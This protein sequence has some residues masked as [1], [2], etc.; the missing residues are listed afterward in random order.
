VNN[1]AGVATLSPSGVA[2]AG[3]ATGAVAGTAEITATFGG[4]SGTSILTVNAATLVSVIVSPLSAT[5]SVGDAQQFTAMANYSFGPDVDVTENAGTVWTTANNPVGVP[6]TLVA[7]MSP[8]GVVGAGLATGLVDGTSDIT[9]TYNLMTDTATLI[10]EEVVIIPGAVCTVDSGPTIP[11]V[12]ESNPTDGNLL[13]TT[14]TAGVANNGKLITANFDMVMD[15]TTIASAT[16][17]LTFTIMETVSL[18][19]VSGT[20]TMDLTNTIATFTTDAALLE[21]MAYTASITSDAM[22]AGG[23]AIA[24]PYEWNFTTVTPAAI[25]VGPVNLGTAASFGIA[26]VAGVENTGA[27]QI[28]GDVVLNTLDQCNAVTVDNAGGFGLCGGTPPT[29]NGEVITPT[30]PDLTTA[31]NVTDDLRAA[32]LSITPANMP[33]ATA[34]AAGTTLGAPIGNA[35]VE[36]DNLFF[37]GVYQSIT[38]I[39]ITGDLTLDAQGDPDAVFVFQSSSPLAQIPTVAYSW[40]A[41]PRLPMSGGRHRPLRPYKLILSGRATSWPQEM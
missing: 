32:Y 9:A 40:S 25:G 17:P 7:S 18:N 12:T 8:N 41:V 23:I 29:I 11:T 30:Y 24:C 34:I 19:Q 27:T 2:G 21:D 36:G 14:S 13:A 4:Q 10:V 5:I 22:S 35:L 38:S 33:G 39:L 15:P 1:P 26:A 37:P 6:A 16:A 20:V 3:L 31:Q 28:D